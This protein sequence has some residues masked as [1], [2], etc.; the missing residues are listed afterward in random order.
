MLVQISVLSKHVFPVLVHIAVTLI[1]IVSVSHK[2]YVFIFIP[3]VNR[4]L[5]HRCYAQQKIPRRNARH[6]FARDYTPDH[7]LLTTTTQ[8]CFST[9]RRQT[10]AR[11]RGYHSSAC[12]CARS[13]AGLQ[14]GAY[15]RPTR[16]PRPTSSGCCTA[17]WNSWAS[18]V[19]GWSILHIRPP[20]LSDLKA[21]RVRRK[22]LQPWKN[23]KDA[24]YTSDM[25]GRN[26]RISGKHPIY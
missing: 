11:L 3:P 7:R 12:C 10:W 8:P 4:S 22:V 19:R 1:Y 26:F 20:T 24:K 21:F 6:L 15:A 18:P 14:R 2:E 16:C 25:K 13:S 5:S 23:A 9:R 17:S